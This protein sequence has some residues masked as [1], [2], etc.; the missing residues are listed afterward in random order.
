MG[1]MDRLIYFILGVICFV[2]GISAIPATFGV[3]VF[4]FRVPAKYFLCKAFEDL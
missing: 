1:A 2:L 3:S 4:I